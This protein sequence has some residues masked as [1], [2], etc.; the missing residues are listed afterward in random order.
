MEV[1][2]GGGGGG[3]VCWWRTGPDRSGADRSQS[4]VSYQC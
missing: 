2:G 4:A 3:G 1:V